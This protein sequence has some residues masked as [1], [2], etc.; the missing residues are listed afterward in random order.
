[1]RRFTWA[2]AAA[3]TAAI[4]VSALPNQPAAVAATAG[5]GPGV[6]APIPCPPIFSP[7]CQ[8][9]YKAVCTQWG[10]HKGAKPVRCCTKMACVPEPH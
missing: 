1:M 2:A 6:V 7:K 3:A 8:K 4:V 9:Y 10:V 5:K